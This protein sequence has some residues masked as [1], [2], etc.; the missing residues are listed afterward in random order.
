[1]SMFETMVKDYAGFRNIGYLVLDKE[2]TLYQKIDSKTFFLRNIQFSKIYI[3][4]RLPGAKKGCPWSDQQAEF[5]IVILI[6]AV[7]PDALSDASTRLTPIL[8]FDST[9]LP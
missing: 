3:T 6:L 8:D 5:H 7:A 1:M 2:K 9:S 4:F